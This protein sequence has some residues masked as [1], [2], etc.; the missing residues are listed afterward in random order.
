MTDVPQLD[1]PGCAAFRAKV[2]AL[3]PDANGGEAIVQDDEEDEASMRSITR[4][5]L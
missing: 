4:T 3:H 1:E 2:R 5:R